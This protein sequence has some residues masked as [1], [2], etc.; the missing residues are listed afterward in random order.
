MESIKTNYGRDIKIFARTVERDTLAQ[1]E[2]LAGVDAYKN[3]KVR[4]MP[5]CHTGAGCPIGLTMT[6]E[7]KVTPNLVGVDIGCGMLTVRLEEKEIDP[8]QLDEVINRFIPSGFGVHKKP[9]GGFDLGKLKCKGA[10]DLPRAYKAIGTL[11]GGN[12]FIEVGKNDQG[13]LFLVVHS[14]SRHPGLQVAEYYQHVAVKN[15][16]GHS[17]AKR[18]RHKTTVKKDLAYLTGR[19]Y[20]NYMHDMK[21][22]QAYASLNRRT[23]VDIILDRAGLHEQS[24]FETIHNY[25]DFNRMILRKGAVRAEKGEKLLIPINMRDGSLICI[26][27]GNSDWNFSA[28]HGAGRLMSRRKA[29]EKLQL[30]DFV[31]QMKGIYTTSVGKATLDEAPDAY[32]PMDEITGMI[33]ETVEIIDRIRPVYNFKAH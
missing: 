33:G 12:H 31:N 26:G 8:E 27:K 30:S 19:D 21:L 18:K 6:I 13:A 29:R 16:N 32:K 15:I 24:S 1:I 9:V 3:A 4:V 7:D 10:I 22:M 25:I 20:E 2:A 5:D 23:M 11:G 17:A 28:P 14:G